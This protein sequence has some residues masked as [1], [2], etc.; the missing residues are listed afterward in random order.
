[1]A[2]RKPFPSGRA[3]TRIL[4]GECYHGGSQSE[5]ACVHRR[6]AADPISVR[7]RARV[8]RPPRALVRRMLR[9]TWV[10]QS[11]AW[12]RSRGRRARRHDV[13]VRRLY[14][15][16]RLVDP[17]GPHGPSCLPVSAASDHP[18]RSRN[19]VARNAAHHI[20]EVRREKRTEGYCQ[21]SVSRADVAPFRDGRATRAHSAAS[22]LV[23][24]VSARRGNRRPHRLR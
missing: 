21:G 15:K 11:Q 8:A 19:Q 3:F 18:K 24:V 6:T 5:G 14:C 9:G 4:K 23:P 12:P 22:I 2:F 16:Y 10:R 7:A 13:M 1:M 17:A 20:A